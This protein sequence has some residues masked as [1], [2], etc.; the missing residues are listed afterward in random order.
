MIG[1]T[2]TAL[3]GLLTFHQEGKP[4]PKSKPTMH[5]IQKHP[6]AHV[7]YADAATDNKQAA[8]WELVD[9]LIFA[10]GKIN[11]VA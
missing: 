5:G 3:E 11:A 4:P 9:D 8:T 1:K 10:A 2:N 6:T 7:A